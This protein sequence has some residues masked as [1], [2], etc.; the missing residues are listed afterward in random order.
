MKALIFAAGLGTRLRPLTDT[1]PKAL[2][3]IGRVPMLE[4]V[5]RSLYN[6]GI[7]QIVVNVHH[8]ASMIKS[9][10]SQL[11]DRNPHP[12]LISDES[13]KLLDTGGGLVKALELLGT[14]EPVL[15]FNADIFTDLDLRDM[16]HQFSAS[17]CDALLLVAHRNTSR[18]L[19]IDNDNMMKG[20]INTS[21]NQVLPQ[22]INAD[23]L[24]PVAF[25]GIHIVAP[26]MLSAIKQYATRVGDVFSI[27]P[28]YIDQ[29][30]SL[31]I[32][33]YQPPTKYRWHDIGKLET[34]SAL[35]QEFQ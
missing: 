18:Y 21:T 24:N 29:C 25:G 27:M 9:F 12:I 2:I 11:N 31:L 19:L 23:D 6:A 10:I 3:E 26:S 13:D 14:D 22:S 4:R 20:W 5:I 8:H 17:S 35:R 16:M 1:C 32:S 34:L 33:T 15:L 30:Q 28:F 7:D